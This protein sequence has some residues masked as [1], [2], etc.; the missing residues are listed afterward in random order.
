MI[1]NEMKIY[2]ILLMLKLYQLGNQIYLIFI[3][4]FIIFQTIKL[5]QPGN[6][7]KRNFHFRVSNQKQTCS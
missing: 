4:G 6:F 5:N 3:F 7:S 1:I 2:I